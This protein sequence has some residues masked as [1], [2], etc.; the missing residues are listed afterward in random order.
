MISPSAHYDLVFVGAGHSH[1]LALR[2]LAM[3]PIPG[4]RLT[5]VSPDSLSAYS[6]MLPGLI[7]GHYTL[8][9]THVDVYRLCQAS[10]CRFIQASVTQLDPQQRHLQLSDGSQLAYDW[11]SLDVGATP[12]LSPLGGSHPRVVP[13]KPVASFYARWQQLCQHAER[14]SPSLAVI[15]AGAGGTEMTLAMAQHFQ[16]HQQPAQIQLITSGNLL[17]GFPASVRE[18]MHKRLQAHNVTLHTDSRVHCDAH[19]QLHM[20]DQPLT[21]QWVLWCTGV[22]GLPILENSGLECDERGFVRVTETLQT[23]TDKR[24]FAA[25]D[26][27]A[28]PTPL[29]KAGVYAVRQARTLATNLRAVIQGQPLV[30]YRPQ[31]RFLSLLSTGGKD[32]IASRGGR[33]SVAGHWVW[34]WK[35][36]IDRA[37]MAKFD[38]Q[39][40][41][42]PPGPADPDTLHCAG[43]GAKVGSDAL[44]EAL[45][46]LQPVVNPGIE[47]GVDAADDAAIIDWPAGQRLVQSLDFFP[48][49]IDEPYLFGRIAALHSLSDV[50]AMNAQPHS[51]LA[52]ITLPWHHPRLQSRDL[53]RMMA[54]AVRELNAAGCTL[55]GGHTIEGPQMAAGFTVNGQADPAQLWHKHGARDGDRLILTKPLGSGVQLAAL[56][57]VSRE[58]SSAFHGPWLDTTLRHLL[59]SNH[60]AQQALQGIPVN[61][62]TDITGF[63]LLGHLYEISQQSQV[64][65]SVDCHKVPLLPGTLSLIEQGVASTLSDANRQI[66]VHCQQQQ[67]VAEALLTALC[68]P[69]TAGGL[70]FCLHADYAKQALQRLDS[71]GIAAA[72]IGKVLVK[73][74]SND[75][76]ILLNS[77]H[78]GK[79]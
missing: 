31:S 29:P 12:D 67:P 48:A 66:L 68:D 36:H 64:S 57:Q 6:G 40:P 19:Q 35:D 23:A 51:A 75:A 28:F 1:A 25:G 9:D 5:L 58:P 59:I 65:L 44:H 39:L 16:R 53:Q 17:P 30:A 7:A 37:F 60:L 46:E 2:M 43:C 52:N 27:A 20:G 42:M 22:R 79:V 13:V 72:E 56:M 8:D 71:K 24:I 21:A 33:L 50:Y 10:G 61:A 41:S 15:G 69:Q 3:K 62:C 26:C 38:Q 78:T 45:A 14:Q 18:K 4:V 32:A 76:A 49:F 54:G 70:L 63:G 77:G 11:L 47:A 74:P 34:R 73:K 55:V